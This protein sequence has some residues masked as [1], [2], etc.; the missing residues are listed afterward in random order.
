MADGGKLAELLAKKKAARAE[1][2]SSAHPSNSRT[3]YSGAHVTSQYEGLYFSYVLLMDVFNF[4]LTTF[5][6][7]RRG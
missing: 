5:R 4:P 7:F 1:R 2:P 3:A 6:S